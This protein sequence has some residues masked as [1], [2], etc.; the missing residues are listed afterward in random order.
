M[1]YIEPEYDEGSV[2]HSLSF[3]SIAEVRD[4]PYFYIRHPIR[5][6]SNLNKLQQQVSNKLVSEPVL[7]HPGLDRGVNI[8]KKR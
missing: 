7:T 1:P 6:G 5:S 8:S 4:G 3:E 2:K